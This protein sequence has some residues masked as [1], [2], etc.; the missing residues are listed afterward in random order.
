MPLGANMAA[1]R[2][3]L[4]RIGG[5]RTDL[6]RSSGRLMLGQEVPELLA[7]ARAAG[8]RGVYLP[9]MA[10]RHHVPARG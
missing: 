3:M 10:L 6:G 8:F 1:R 5:F 2:T 9:A 4:T 7:R